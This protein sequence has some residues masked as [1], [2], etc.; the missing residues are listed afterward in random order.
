MI[1]PLS[2]D[3]YPPN[4]LEGLIAG[5]WVKRIEEWGELCHTINPAMIQEVI[6]ETR[7]AMYAA[8]WT[9]LYQHKFLAQLRKDLTELTE[10]HLLTRQ[11]ISHLDLELESH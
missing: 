10:G 7:A 3:V 8:K 6:C 1:P 9:P 4:T 11:F 5:R 2:I